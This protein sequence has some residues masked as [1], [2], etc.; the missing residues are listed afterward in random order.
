MA[1]ATYETITR[2]EI[3]A[4]V[5]KRL[6]LTHTTSE[7]TTLIQHLR[8]AAE[9]M[10]TVLDTPQFEAILPIDCYIAELP[11]NFITFNEGSECNPPLVFTRDGQVI[12]AHQTTPYL[13]CGN[14]SVT[15]TGGPFFQCS[16]Y[17]TDNC[18]YGIP[19]IKIQKGK[20]YFS[21]NIDAD[22][23]KISYMGVNVD[24]S[25]QLLLPMM[26]ARPMENFALYQWSMDNGR[27]WQEYQRVWSTTKKHRKGQANLPNVFQREQI[28]RIMNSLF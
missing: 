28:K 3:L 12:A 9:E 25:G 5:K 24:E 7:D 14:F 21:N 10:D 16:P 6:Q 22:E 11:C 23:C 27:S 8:Q 26:N 13:Y 15:Y 19:V 18:H 2:D 17:N 4:R 1:I 20:I